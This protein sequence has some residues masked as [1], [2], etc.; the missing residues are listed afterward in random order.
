MKILQIS[1]LHF[2]PYFIEKIAQAA[3]EFAAQ[4]S[5]DV[6]VITGDLTQRAKVEQFQQAQ[7]YLEKL[8][9]IAKTLVLIGNHD[10]PLYR[11]IER[12]FQPYRL[13]QKYIHSE[14]DYFTDIN[15]T[16][17]VCLNSTHPYW[18]IKH[19]Y[20]SPGQLTQCRR[21]FLEDGARKIRYRILAMHHHL[22]P[23]PHFGRSSLM[24]NAKSLLRELESLNVNM[25]LS[26]HIHRSFIGNSLDIYAGENRDKGMLLI[27]CGTTT[28]RRGRGAE[29][30]KN[31]LNV[32]AI[33]PDE[34]KV[35]HYM[36][37]SNTDTFQLVSDHAF[38]QVPLSH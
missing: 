16:R 23:V 17:I 12:V 20:I 22:V 38:K 31:S 36:Y 1:D 33:K 21:L 19:G 25:V 2:G 5:A 13:F 34:V 29:R 3:L 7:K 26:G 32:I 24:P 10:I 35:S 37:F 6:I 9:S 4:C 11:I 30:E 15:D 18:R 8:S 27:S 14:L 28:S